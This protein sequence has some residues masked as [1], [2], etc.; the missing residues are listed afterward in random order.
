MFPRP[1]F[2]K[3]L[4]PRTTIPHHLSTMSF[5][6]GNEDSLFSAARCAE[7]GV[8][9]NLEDVLGVYP[10]KI[11]PGERG[12]E[13]LF[14]WVGFDHWPFGETEFGS[15]GETFGSAEDRYRQTI[16]QLDAKWKQVGDKKSGRQ[17]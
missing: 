15:A 17:S 3:R 13:I 11:G 12:T 16:R 1:P 5:F 7:L 4:F 9:L 8:G 6:Q 10:K 14:K 2:R